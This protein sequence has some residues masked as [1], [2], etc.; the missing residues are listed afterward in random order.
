MS[1]INSVPI[2]QIGYGAMGLEGYYGQSEDSSAIEALIHAIDQNIMIDT[3]DA[4]GAGHNE[5]L[6]KQA[7]QQSTRDA[8]VATKFGIV[9]EEDQRGSQLDTGW[10]FPLTIN[11]S[12]TYV[13][14]AI[15]NSLKRLGVEK[16]DLLYAHY[17]DPNTPLEETVSAMAE[18]VREGK[19]KTIGLS[20]VTADE[21]IR[22]N[23]VHPIS[24]VQYEYSLFRREAEN[25]ILP[26]VKSIG[27]ALVCWS[28]LGA[29]FLTGTIKELDEGDFRT[30]NPKMQG[31][32]FTN[33]LQR[34]EHIKKIAV[35]LSVTPAQLA[36]AWL[37]A[38][39]DNIIPIP[40]TR[41][42]SHIDENLAAL[43][44]Q[45]SSDA[46][47]ELDSNA[48]IGAFKGATLV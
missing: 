6:I 22:A 7:M 42:K 23:K 41:K 28:P 34:L 15:E 16:I 31:E 3:A 25:D 40:G 45:L 18:A 30:N 33:N 27:A 17:L 13:K 47:G 10:G 1:T 20:N 39:G 24:A 9:F 48:P 37:I 38:Q 32:N 5:M 14:R 44:I 12:K 4:Y 43:D 19:V 29:G 11:C 46:I 8:F 36:L 35:D 26:A 21:I 2:K